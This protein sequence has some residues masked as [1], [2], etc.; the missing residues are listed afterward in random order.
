MLGTYENIDC[1]ELMAN[2]K[3]KE[4]DLAIV[5]PDFGIHKKLSRGEAGQHNFHKLYR[6]N[7]WVDERP[8]KEYFQELERVS[9]NQI[10]FGGN[11]FVEYLKNSSGWIYWNKL[12][13]S[14]VSFSDGE[15]AYT[16][17]DYPLREA[18]IL[19]DGFRKVE[20][21][22]MIHACQKPISLYKWCLA[23]YAEKGFL[24][25]D[26]HVGSASSLIAYE[27]EGYEYIACEKNKIIYD[28]SLQRLKSHL[29]QEKLFQRVGRDEIHLSQPSMFA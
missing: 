28:K 13:G 7:G 25:L 11:Y 17:Y 4:V 23:N 21:T 22:E 1:M 18:K 29:L 2:L 12:R 10:I 9:K 3:D 15:L 26:T 5:D 20:Q 8:S 6:D 24:I 27:D 19:W 16:S 14:N